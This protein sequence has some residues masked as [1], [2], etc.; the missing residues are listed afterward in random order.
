MLGAKSDGNKVTKI[1]KI[2]T[3]AAY[4]LCGEVKKAMADYLEGIQKAY[5]ANKQKELE[6]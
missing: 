1:D 6:R 4:A 3:D 5:L 2:L